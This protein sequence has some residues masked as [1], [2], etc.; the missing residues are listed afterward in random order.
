MQMFKLSDRRKEDRLSA[1][2]Q[3]VI[4]IES[5]MPEI[6]KRKRQILNN[7]YEFFKQT[8][9]FFGMKNFTLKTKL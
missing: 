2:N 1:Q 8:G 5:L 6:E 9:E 3:A 4:S 7:F